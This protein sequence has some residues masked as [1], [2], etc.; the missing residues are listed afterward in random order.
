L[1]RKKWLRLNSLIKVRELEYSYKNGGRSIFVPVSFS[2]E[3]GESLGLRGENGSGKT[4]ILKIVASLIRPTAGEILFRGCDLYS[5]LKG[6]RRI[7]NYSAG[8]PMG[9]YPRL[10]G[11]E[12]LRFFSAMKGQMIAEQEARRS[13]ARVGLL[14]ADSLKKYH[15]FSLGMKQRLHIARLLLEPCEALLL[16]EPTNGLS[17]EGVSLLIEILNRDLAAKAKLIV[18]HD[19]WFLRQV[20]ARN[21]DIVPNQGGEYE[22]TL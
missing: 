22:P 18:S 6:Y 17:I 1:V 11:I 3:P 20:S 19:G 15:Q 2:L 14:E 9:F 4:T 10:N 21:I 5:Q 16:D 7:I 12:N 8:A 13:L